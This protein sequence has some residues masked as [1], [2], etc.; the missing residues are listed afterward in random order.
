MKP[1]LD[2]IEQTRCMKC[3]AATARYYGKWASEGLCRPCVLGMQA[4]IRLKVLRDMHPADRKRWQLDGLFSGADDADVRP[5]A[6]PGEPS[7]RD[8]AKMLE[9]VEK[10][11]ESA[12]Q[13]C[14][15][16]VGAKIVTGGRRSTPT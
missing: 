6:S 11:S 3:R 2:P 9:A 4:E 15:D 5:D 8:L 16:K 7:E 12:V 14:A 13:E 10:G 1:V